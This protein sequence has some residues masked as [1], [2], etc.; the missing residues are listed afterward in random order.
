MT[1]PEPWSGPSISPSGEW[2]A[3][4]VVGGRS[5]DLEGPESA[6]GGYGLI[7]GSGVEVSFGG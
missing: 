7:C 3:S 6:D 1:T 5:V 4:R 2:R